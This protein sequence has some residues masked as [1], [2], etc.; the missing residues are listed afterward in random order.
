MSGREA[1]PGEQLRT[2]RVGILQFESI[3]VSR[4]EFG[5]ELAKL[6]AGAWSQ[7]PGGEV[8]EMACRTRSA[9]LCGWTRVRVPCA[10]SEHHRETIE[11]LGK[12][13]WWE[14]GE[15]QE[16]DFLP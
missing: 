16:V 11:E 1:R 15:P 6:R 7:R 14:E 5:N 9:G 4:A 10:I 12:Q 3:R 2:C 8:R 13:S